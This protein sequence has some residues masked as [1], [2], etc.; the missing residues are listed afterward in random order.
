MDYVVAL[1]PSIGLAI[2]FV[3]VL[4][5]ILLADRRERAAIRELDEAEAAA[6]DVVGRDN[7]ANGN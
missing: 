4:R 3:I 1:L 5:A 2:L 7:S 6:A